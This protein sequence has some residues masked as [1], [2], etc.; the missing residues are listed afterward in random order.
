MFEK[1]KRKKKNMFLWKD[2]QPIS[3]MEKTDMAR[4]ICLL[5]AYDHDKEQV[6]SYVEKG[7]R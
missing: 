6:F 1:L 2:V 7:F 3:D 5:K 4:P